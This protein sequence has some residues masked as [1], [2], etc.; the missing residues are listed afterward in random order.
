MRNAQTELL[1][2]LIINERYGGEAYGPEATDNPNL[3][4]KPM[5]Y[6]CTT[7]LVDCDWYDYDSVKLLFEELYDM[8]N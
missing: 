6:F 5:S 2:Q 3:D 7:N 4:A 1:D 8:L